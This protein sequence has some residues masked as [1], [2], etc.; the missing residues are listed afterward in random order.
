MILTVSE[1]IFLEQRFRG[2]KLDTRT[3][4]TGRN[5]NNLG[6]FP[7]QKKRLLIS[8]VLKAK[9]NNGDRLQLAGVRHLA[10][11]KNQRGQT[12]A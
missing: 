12:R 1:N 3:R 6:P 10:R 5:S 9:R 8:L 11:A 2:R 7:T 4:Q